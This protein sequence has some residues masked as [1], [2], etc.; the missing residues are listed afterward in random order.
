MRMV[1]EDELSNVI[2]VLGGYSTVAA[3]PPPPLPPPPPPPPPYR[4][5]VARALRPPASPAPSAPPPQHSRVTPED[6]QA[7]LPPTTASMDQKTQSSFQVSRLLF[8]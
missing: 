1:N 3:F 2:D 5:Q 4:S 8:L 7:L 6:L